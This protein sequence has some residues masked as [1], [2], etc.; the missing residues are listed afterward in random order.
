MDE[1]IDIIQTC[2]K[3]QQIQT[4]VIIFLCALNHIAF[5]LLPFFTKKPTFLCSPKEDYNPSFLECTESLA[6]DNLHFTYIIDSSSSFR[7]WAFDFKL[8][9]NSFNYAI[10][11]SYAY[12]LGGLL[13]SY[14]LSYVG[15]KFGRRLLSRILAL[16][17]LTCHL[18]FLLAFS[19][20]MIVCLCFVIGLSSYSIIL[21]TIIIAEYLTRPNSA[22][23]ISINT[24]IGYLLAMLCVLI[25]IYINNS[26]II[27]I[28][29]SGLS[30][31][32]CFFLF[33]YL[34]ESHFWLISR[35]RL[36]ECFDLLKNIAELNNRM[37]DYIRIESMK[38]YKLTDN[39]AIITRYDNIIRILRYD[40]QRRRLII[41]SIIFFCSSLCFFNS[42]C[43]IDSLNYNFNVKY[44]ILF[45]IIFIS[46]I[47]IG[48][49]GDIY[50]RKVCVNYSLY[51]C[52]FFNFIY[53][54]LPQN[55]WIKVM[56]FTMAL[57]GGS[58]SYSILY[59]FTSEDFPTFI[60]CTVMGIMFALSRIGGI[61]TVYLKDN[62]HQFEIIFAFLSCGAGRLAE[63]LEDTFEMILDDEVPENKIDGPYKK[64]TTRAVRRKKKSE[65]S[66]VYFLTSDDESFNKGQTYI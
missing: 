63:L 19:K 15:D 65:L 3:T 28:L 56:S 1:A 35:N 46:Q 32:I 50:G 60:R 52:G 47:S 61:L 5:I 10:A 53:A 55:N 44:F 58:A 33:N 40:S 22:L 45:F 38:N 62:G 8:Y 39:I 49:L 26:T 57:I 11:F 27:F 59:V 48:I 17:T 21:S 31:I 30:T 36:L 34:L 6:C 14:P 54:I 37:G 18:L 29:T 12:L 23:L 25:Y 42:I 41:H 2:G 4:I 20:Y 64:K 16:I 24:S 9:C 51:F 43:V 66:D 7:N 13:S